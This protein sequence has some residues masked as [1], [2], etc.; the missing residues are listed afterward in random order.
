MTAA[1]A[2]AV[3]TCPWWCDGIRPGHES[4][5]GEHFSEG[6]HV[7][8]LEQLRAEI[9]DASMSV[10]L[11]Q[12]AD[13]GRSRSYAPRIHVV[14][15]VSNELTPDQ[16]K[17]LLVAIADQLARLD[18]TLGS[19]GRGD[20]CPPCCTTAHLHDDEDQQQAQDGGALHWGP[21][22]EG[23]RDKFDVQMASVTDKEGFTPPNYPIIHM[24]SETITAN[25]ARRLALA[26]LHAAALADIADGTA[27][28]ADRS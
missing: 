14:G 2:T 7:P 22:L 24:G 8:V 17:R 13:P 6:A 21:Y 10:A 28:R 11:H 16:A 25:E 3:T 27:A 19:A 26:L 15:G 23:A 5:D 4:D 18:P 1:A 12:P 9:L 20:Y